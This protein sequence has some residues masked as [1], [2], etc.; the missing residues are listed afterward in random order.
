MHGGPLLLRLR[1]PNRC[2]EEPARA[3]RPS[4]SSLR[5]A[6]LNCRDRER[7]LNSDA[8]LPLCSGE[9]GAST[10][11]LSTAVRQPCGGAA[12]AIAV[13]Y[14]I[15]CHGNRIIVRS[16]PPSA[17]SSALAAGQFQT[18]VSK[19]CRANQLS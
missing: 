6:A 2:E 9:A 17:R 3:A 14:V 15:C 5:S 18:S 11:G 7:D 13:A 1:V 16:A 4:A 10:A 12:S 19:L 8:G